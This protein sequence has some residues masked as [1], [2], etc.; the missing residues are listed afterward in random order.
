MS[1]S[2]R[3]HTVKAF[4][5]DLNRL[6]GL[7]SEMGARAVMSITTAMTALDQRDG[8][9]AQAIISADS[10]IDDLEADIEKLVVQTIAL[11]APMA[12]DLRTMVAALKIAAVLERVGD[13]GKNIAKRVP[14]LA[15]DRSI[16]AIPLLLSITELACDMLRE[17][18]ESYAAQDAA[19]ALE[20]C[21]RD[22]MVDDF[23]NA[24]FRAL[25]TYMMENPRAISE[26]AH[27]LFVAKNIERVGDH[28]TNV[29]EMVYYVAT[30]QHMDQREKG[31]SPASVTTDRQQQG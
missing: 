21:R 16:E 13:Y 8:A 28:A 24:I 23:Y 2:N 9:T 15:N 5:D 20:V 1:V 12:D 10:V 19:R 4:D 27:L 7:V 22:K 3:D 26:S 17:A 29:A 18:L 25:I 6:R 11:R 31:A 30:G 14:M